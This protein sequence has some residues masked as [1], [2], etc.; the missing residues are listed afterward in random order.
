MKK[1]IT[2]ALC[3]LILSSCN[4]DNVVKVSKDEYNK[5]KGVPQQKVFK[6]GGKFMK[7]LQLVIVVNIIQCVSLLVGIQIT[8][9][10][11]TTPSVHIVKKI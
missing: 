1:L 9:N 7:L 6:V 10:I 5:L 8:Y 11:S 4:D 2:F 3:C